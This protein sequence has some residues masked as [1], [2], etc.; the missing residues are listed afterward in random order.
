VFKILDP[1]KTNSTWM[2]K[3]SRPTSFAGFADTVA[4]MLERDDFDKRYTT[5]QPIAIHEFL[6]RWYR[7][8]TRWRLRTSSWA[9]PI[10]S[11]TC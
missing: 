10:R 11:S 5:N 4:R 8:M 7:A 3:L 6:Y 1:A 9:V 2:D